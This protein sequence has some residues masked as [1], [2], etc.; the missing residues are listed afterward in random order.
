MSQV[1]GQPLGPFQ[2]ASGTLALFGVLALL[3]ACLGIYGVVAYAV[4][5]RLSEFGIRIALGADAGDILGLVMKHGAALAGI[6]TAIG[7]AIAVALS[8]MASGSMPGVTRP[9]P[10]LF[11][12]VALPLI[13]AAL[14]ASYL[15]ARRATKVDPASALRSE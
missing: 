9:G 1:V 3:L 2:L 5:R 14:T 15:P 7:L 6:G 10:L 11:A 12:G 4:N 13:A 8:M